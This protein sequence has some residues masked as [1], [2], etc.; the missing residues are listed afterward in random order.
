MALNIFLLIF[1]LDKGNRPNTKDGG[2]KKDHWNPLPQWATDDPKKSIGMF[3]T[4]GR[5]S[6]S[7]QV[8]HP[9]YY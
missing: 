5:F 3:D 6:T 2:E 9:H 8:P 1:S 7:D 4:K